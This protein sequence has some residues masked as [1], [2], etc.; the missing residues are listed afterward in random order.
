MPLAA[1]P[2]GPF[3][4]VRGTVTY[5]DPE[6]G[7]V[8]SRLVRESTGIGAG[9][10]EATAQ[11]WAVRREAAIL[12]QLAGEHVR[13]DEPRINAITFGQAA[14]SWLA[15]RPRGRSDKQRV[16]RL[17][18]HWPLKRVVEINNDAACDEAADAL[19]RKAQT[20]GG[21]RRAVHALVSSI[22]SHAG[23]KWQEHGKPKL[24]SAITTQARAAK[25]TDWLT[26]DQA[27][28]L[29]RNAAPHVRPLFLFLIGTGARVGE[30]LTL[31]WSDVDLAAG[32]C[33]LRNDEERRTKNGRDRHI[34]LPPAV[35]AALASLRHRD[36]EVFRTSAT[37]RMTRLGLLPPPYRGEAGQFKTA[38]RG[39]MRR[40]GL[41]A[42]ERAAGATIQCAGP[43]TPVRWLPRLSPHALRHTWA[44]WFY[45]ATRDAIRLKEAGGWSSLELVDRYTH[46][47][48][49]SAIGAIA[50]IWGCASP[51]DFPAAAARRIG[52]RSTHGHAAQG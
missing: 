39:A 36:G 3:W 43:C 37:K 5:K 7:E 24:V 12:K 32:T 14:H 20:D 47:M 8:R 48:P 49:S 40:A 29:L 35:V 2:R 27:A 26:P 51:D 1:Y 9:L 22:V 15:L 18:S 4:H 44:S 23:D 41:I 11:A 50:T 19:C 46:L 31:R 28:A 42:W 16:G 6:T 30:A 17:V 10:P 52:T 33:V 38:W 34:D 13:R 25:R 45:A 21:R